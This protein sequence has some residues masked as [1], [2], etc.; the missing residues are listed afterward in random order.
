MNMGTLSN[1]VK[2]V[3]Y[4]FFFTPILSS[5]LHESQHKFTCNT[6]NMPINML[7]LEIGKYH[8]KKYKGKMEG[9]KKLEKNKR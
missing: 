7:C 4:S 3:F 8:G 6:N 2:S 9:K 1:H 5:F